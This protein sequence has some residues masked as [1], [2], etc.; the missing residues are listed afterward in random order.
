MSDFVLGSRHGE[1]GEGLSSPDVSGTDL[2][3][4]IRLRGEGL[5]K[6]DQM[7]R[8]V[9]EIE[10][11]VTQGEIAGLLGPS[12]A[13][14]AGCAQPFRSRSSAPYAEQTIGIESA[15]TIPDDERSVF[16]CNRTEPRHPR[17][18]K[19][20]DYRVDKPSSDSCC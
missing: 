20:A 9:E 10:I 6:I 7:R 17:E 18:T 5:L 19:G 14:T 1:D 3:V 11:P 2:A 13:G 16:D 15:A 8:V 12:R 4:P